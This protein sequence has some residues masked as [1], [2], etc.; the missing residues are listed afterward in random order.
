VHH[1][2]IADLLPTLEGVATFERL[3][4]IGDVSD[5]LRTEMKGVA[6]GFFSVSNGIERR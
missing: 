3:D 2:H 1:F 6:S 5:E 4:V